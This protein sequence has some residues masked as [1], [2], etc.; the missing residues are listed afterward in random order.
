MREISS[1]L[2]LRLPPI[3]PA[4]WEAW[5]NRVLKNPVKSLRD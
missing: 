2:A 5:L 4:S 1:M 3:Q